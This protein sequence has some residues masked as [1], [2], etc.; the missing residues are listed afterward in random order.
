MTSIWAFTLGAMFSTQVLLCHL[1]SV[2]E[3]DMSQV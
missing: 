1:I 3:N 2:A